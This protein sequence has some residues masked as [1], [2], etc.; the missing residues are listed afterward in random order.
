MDWT[1]PNVEAMILSRLFALATLVTA[2]PSLQ[3]QA[4]T[5]GLFL[6]NAAKPLPDTF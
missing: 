2:I 5:V 6:N 4:Q 1:I 3:G